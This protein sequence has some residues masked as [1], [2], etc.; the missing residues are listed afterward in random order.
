MMNT[1]LKNWKECKVEKIKAK[2]LR[3]NFEIAH[4]QYFPRK[5]KNMVV[6]NV[7]TEHPANTLDMESAYAERL[8]AHELLSRNPLVEQIQLEDAKQAMTKSH[9]PDPIMPPTS[10]APNEFLR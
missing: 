1:A 3:R 10:P 7:M 6:Q 8:P 4:H 2:K 5:R 9:S